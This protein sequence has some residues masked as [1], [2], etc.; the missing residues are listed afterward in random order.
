MKLSFKQ[1]LIL[2]LMLFVTFVGCAEYAAQREASTN[3]K[4]IKSQQDQLTQ[5]DNDL[6]KLNTET[7]KGLVEKNQLMQEL[8]PVQVALNHGYGKEVGFT[9]IKEAKKYDLRPSFIM[10]LIETESTWR[11]HSPNSATATG[12]MQ[13]TK[14]TGT[15]L[16]RDLEISNPDL[17]D[18][19]TNIKLGTYCIASLIRTY[20]DVHT[21]L[22]AYNQG[23]GGMQEYVA[24]Y[25]TSRSG[26]SR[27][28]ISYQEHYE[29]Q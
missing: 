29:N 16:A 20:G 14:R 5:I 23:E 22:T 26:Y 25:G 19:V 18:P 28:V 9:I 1:I 11:N 13:V 7:D 4:A 2:M 24:Y 6:G 10:G 21:A 27:K 3:L 12:L 8:Y 17:M 15:S